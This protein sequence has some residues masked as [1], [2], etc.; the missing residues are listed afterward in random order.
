MVY[1]TK[2]SNGLISDMDFTKYSQ[3]EQIKKSLPN[4]GCDVT[5]DDKLTIDKFLENRFSNLNADLNNRLSTL[6]EV[7][8]K[9]FSWFFSLKLKNLT[10]NNRHN[11]PLHIS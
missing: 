2:K 5:V 7:L 3:N 4:V 6:Y 11:H 9:D 1:I 8:K 10:M